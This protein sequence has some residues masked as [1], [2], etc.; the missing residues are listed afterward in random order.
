MYKRQ[1]QGQ[2][3]TGLVVRGASAY[4]IEIDDI[5]TSGITQTFGINIENITSGSYNVG[6]RIKNIGNTGID[7]FNPGTYGIYIT[8]PSQAGV[9]IHAEKYGVWTTDDAG[10]GRAGV[11]A[12]GFAHGFWSYDA[13]SFGLFIEQSNSHGIFIDA[14]SGDGIRIDY[15]SHNGMY[16]YEP[17]WDGIGIFSPGDDGV[18]VQSPADNCFEC[19]GS[20][21]S[22]FKV[23]GECD[24]YGHS[25]N[26]YILDDAGK[27]IVAP[28]IVSTDSWIEHIGEAKLENGV[29]IIKFPDVFLRGMEDDSDVEVFITPYSPM[30]NYWV[31]RAD[32]YVIV[33][34]GEGGFQNAEFAYRILA[35]TNSN[36]KYKAKFV[37]IIDEIN[38]EQ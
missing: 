37:N 2:A 13:D 18:D 23:T 9:E 38:D 1:V 4:G 30:G 14:P 3:D 5:G 6:I 21:V 28:V 8:G 20:P 24:V 35:K 27:G 19:N 16:I 36:G 32:E 22:L 25:Y 34:G 29:C 11:K 12:S 17:G 10:G 31:E 26:M 33:H 7:M 15:S